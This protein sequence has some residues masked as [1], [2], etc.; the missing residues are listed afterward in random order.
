MRYLARFWL[1][2]AL[3]ASG[4][5]LAQGE[6]GPTDENALK[7]PWP[8]EGAKGEMFRD[9][10]GSL[11][12]PTCTGLSVLES[13]ARFS[14]Q[15]KELVLEQVEAGKPKDEILAFFTERYGPWILRAPP[16]SGVNLLAWVLPLGLLILGPPIVWL[17]VWR[18]RRVVS[19]F[20]VRPVADVMK[21]FEDRL[22][23]MRAP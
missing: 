11:R 18:R 6:A 12:C 20:G 8:S 9:V 16:K 22:A 19:T 1:W 17:T 14:Q 4:L 15:I 7:K 13:D 5:C 3:T 10:A 23:A 2:M 21:E